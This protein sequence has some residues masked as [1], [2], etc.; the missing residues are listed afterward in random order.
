[1][2]RSYAPTELKR[3][4]KPALEELE[5]LG[6]LE[7]LSPEERYSYVKRG[8]WRII[9]IR[10]RHA[11]AE[12]EPAGLEASPPSWSRRS[13]REGSPPGRPQEL[14]EAHS[15][16]P[17]PD[18]D[19]GLRLADPQRGQAGR[20][21][22]R[23]LSRRLD[24]IGL[25]GPRR[26]SSRPTPS[27]DCLEQAEAC[28]RARLPSARQTSRPR[29]SDDRGPRG[30]APCRLGAA[31]RRRARG[32]PGRRQGREPG[33]EPLEEHARAPLPR[34]ARGPAPRKPSRRE[35]GPA[36]PGCR[37]D[38][39]RPGRQLP[40]GMASPRLRGRAASNSAARPR[41]RRPGR[42]PA[43]RSAP[44]RR[45]RESYRTIEATRGRSRSLT[46]SERS[47]PTWI[48]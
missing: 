27:R 41:C 12:P 13:R 9:L 30:Q 46:T 2:S 48:A 33:P 14:V 40:S 7:P 31:A 6:F 47:L 24:P 3:R 1:M 25:S 20:Q 11:P 19:R 18:Q 28:R 8:T 4:L 36:L 35:P 29:S 17:D 21:E 34:R 16:H 22:P 10:G 44:P 23:R 26:L 42:R 37:V 45:S 15:G 38:P 43:R 39:P 32:H 5:R